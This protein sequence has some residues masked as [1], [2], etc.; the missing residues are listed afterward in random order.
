MQFALLN[1]MIPGH[2]PRGLIE[3]MISLF[4]TVITYEHRHVSSPP[5][6]LLRQ[7]SAYSVACS[8]SSHTLDFGRTLRCDIFIAKDNFRLTA[9]PVRKTIYVV[10]DLHSAW[11]TK[12]DRCPCFTSRLDCITVFAEDCSGS[13]LFNGFPHYDQLRFSANVCEFMSIS[14]NLGIRR[15]RQQCG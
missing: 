2:R 4:G 1:A 9:G 5:W 8:S 6:L 13:Y 10:N 3:A 12:S 11:P 15:L 14:Y 7:Y